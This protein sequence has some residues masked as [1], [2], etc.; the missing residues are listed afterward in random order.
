MAFLEGLKPL[1]EASARPRPGEADAILQGRL[2]ALSALGGGGLPDRTWE[3]W[4]HSDPSFLWERTFRADPSTPFATDQVPPGVMV[5]TPTGWE[6]APAFPFEGRPLAALQA[7]LSAGVLV[8]RVPKGVRAQAPLLLRNVLPPAGTLTVPSLFL[9][10]EEGASLKAVLSHE[11][12]ED[13]ALTLPAVTALLSAGSSLDW[14]ERDDR[15][16]DPVRIGAFESVLREGAR[17]DAEL[18]LMGGPWTRQDLRVR[19]EG[20]ESRVR[21]HGLTLGG[22]DAHLDVHS[23]LDHAAPA[24]VSEQLFKGVAAGRATVVNNGEVLV[25]EG[26]KG[27]DANQTHRNLVLTDEALVFSEPRLEIHHDDVRCTHGSATG[28]LDEEGVFYLRSRGLDGAEARRLILRAFVAEVFPPEHPLGRA[29]E[30]WMA[31]V[32]ARP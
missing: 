12:G 2:Q 20:R 24:C 3:A 14:T 17:L 13:R 7:A 22:A 10:L 6:E 29:A 11:G 27:T 19:M 31:A 21:L 16:G 32:E 9:L 23:F 1:L 5:T 26:A 25:R 30:E 28:P 4:R 15:A 8:V 18:L